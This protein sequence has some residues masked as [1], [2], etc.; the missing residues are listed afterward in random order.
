MR[1]Q[2]AKPDTAR[3]GDGS[4]TPEMVVD[5][6]KGLVGSDR[7]NAERVID[8]A[9][10]FGVTAAAVAISRGG[11]SVSITVGRGSG[12]ANVLLIGFDP[13]HRTAIGRGE[14]SGRTLTESNIVRSIRSLGSWN[15]TPITFDVPLPQ[16]QRAAVLL[17]APGGSIVG[18]ARSD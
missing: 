17:Q 15:G 14:N 12:S 2:S 13:E 4:Y 8:A 16:G 9:K 10:H 6:R 3:V 1:R 5:G 18:T 11:S 7:A